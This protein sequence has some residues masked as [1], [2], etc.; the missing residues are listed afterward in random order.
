MNRVVAAFPLAFVDDVFVDVPVVDSPL[1]N[2]LPKLEGHFGPHDVEGGNCY[3]HL[4]RVTTSIISHFEFPRRDFD[5]VVGK[6]RCESDGRRGK[7]RD[8]AFGQPNSRSQPLVI[9]S[10]GVATRGT[11]EVGVFHKVSSAHCAFLPGSASLGIRSIVDV[12]IVILVIPIPAPF[13]YVADHVS[14]AIAVCVG[15]TSNRSGE[16]DSGVYDVLFVS[17]VLVGGMVAGVVAL[18]AVGRGFVSFA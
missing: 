7:R 14:Q 1:A 3:V 15:E 18:V 5:K 6:R 8:M 11:G 2:L 9:R 12:P 16:A 4:G 17:S 10:F 13:R